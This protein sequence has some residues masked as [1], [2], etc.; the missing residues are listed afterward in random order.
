MPSE[1]DY[2]IRPIAQDSVMH[3]SKV[4]IAHLRL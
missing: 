2:Q 1:R 3:N 4:C